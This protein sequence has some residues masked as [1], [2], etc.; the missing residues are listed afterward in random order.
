M[1]RGCVFSFFRDHSR[2][3][4]LKL[5]TFVTDTTK[6][7]TLLVLSPQLL[8]YFWIRGFPRTSGRGNVLQN[9][10]QGYLSE[11]VCR[12]KVGSISDNF[13]NF[14]FQDGFSFV[15][16]DKP[17]GA[18]YWSVWSKSTQ[19]EDSE[20]W[21]LFPDVR[22]GVGSNQR[23]V[24]RTVCQLTIYYWMR[25]YTSCSWDSGSQLVPYEITFISRISM[26]ILPTVCPK[27]SG[28]WI[29]KKKIHLEVIINDR[30]GKY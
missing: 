4:F 5:N 7:P 29:N 2:I 8:V 28:I 18:G 11:C 19:L 26:K 3:S 22:A 25:S 21:T 12:D 6:T 13:V 30:D 20:S 10:V 24:K 27:Y 23:R 15:S 16:L 1:K 9:S 17:S 14:I